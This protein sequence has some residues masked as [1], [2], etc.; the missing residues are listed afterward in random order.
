M[1]LEPKKIISP[2][3]GQA[4][5]PQLSKYTQEGKTYEQAVYC[6]PVTG[7][8]I[9]RGIVSITDAKTGNLIQ[10]YRSGSVNSVPSKSYRQ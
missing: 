5:F 4:A 9:R 3:S 7:S 10:D 2:Y 1:F 8:F 6:D